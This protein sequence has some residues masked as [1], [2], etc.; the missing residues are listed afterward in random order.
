M[1]AALW[2]AAS[3]AA[4]G[5]VVLVARMSA[6]GPDRTAPTPAA[7]TTG[8]A[9]TVPGP[10]LGPESET[11]MGLSTETLQGEVSP[12]D[13]RQEVHGNAVI[14]GRL[15][16]ADGPPGETVEL[17]LGTGEDD[18]WR[19][20][21]TVAESGRDGSFR[22]EGLAPDW[23]GVVLLPPHYRLADAQ[24]RGMA[25]RAFPAQAGEQALAI[26]VERLPTLLGRV[27]QATDR[28]PAEGVEVAVQAHWGTALSLHEARTGKDGR[29]RIALRHGSLKELALECRAPDGAALLE[30]REASNLPPA[31]LR[32]DIDLGGLVLGAPRRAW[33][34]VRGPEGSP[35]EGA[36]AVTRGMQRQRTFETDAEGRAELQL[37][38]LS[39]RLEIQAR[40]YSIVEIDTPD[41]GA[42]HELRLVRANRLTIEV[43]DAAGAP[44]PGCQV[45]LSAAES[46]FE[47]GRDLLDDFFTGDQR[48]HGTV[49]GRSA[50][51]VFAY[52]TADAAGRVEL[53]SLSVGLP[54]DLR[55]RDVLGSVGA[56][57]A[58]AGLGSGETRIVRLLLDR[59]L[60]PLLGR[61][62]DSNGRPVVGAQ[63][64]IAGGEELVILESDA[65]GRFASPPLIE[66]SLNL[67]ATAAGFV[68]LALEDVSSAEP[69]E[70]VLERGRSLVVQML[71]GRGERIEVGELDAHLPGAQASWTADRTRGGTWS[72]Q[73][74]PG[75]PLELEFR[76]HGRSIT[77]GVDATSEAYDWKLPELGQLEVDG[78]AFVGALEE[79]CSLLLE[80]V[81]QERGVVEQHDVPKDADLKLALSPWPGRY[82]LRRVVRTWVDIGNGFRKPVD[83]R[84]V[85]EPIEV[86]VRAGETT[87]I[88]LASVP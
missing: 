65:E 1:R 47:G 18:G 14:A 28:A 63:I 72:F 83:A 11:R 88:H 9:A 55:A 12:V 7:S 31:D 24:A 23:T 45:E 26:R 80:S 30:L 13:P 54:L 79:T 32:G 73:G 5:L 16:V 67:Q 61:C 38:G 22:F 60:A 29:F 77:A 3:L 50:D 25:A 19:S 78:P 21:A 68:S 86:E 69:L 70:L 84:D 41:E 81:E 58:C 59:R 82:R 10:T 2:I 52:F 35:I 57:A 66:R 34:V 64:Q 71:D 27:F 20:S 36:R 44:W 87:R 43:V 42:T 33:L 37:A 15:F 49:G 46:P 39:E 53:Q 76:W 8:R 51:R 85:G 62:I 56:R 17:T 74:I 40:G 6:T 48:S 75:V 4:V